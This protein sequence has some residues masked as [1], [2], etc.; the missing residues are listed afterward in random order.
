MKRFFKY[1]QPLISLCIGVFLFWLTFE[2]TPWQEVINR[3]HELDYLWV[4]LSVM[5]GY[6]AYVFRGIRWNLLIKPLGYTVSSITLI[7]AI[8]FSFFCNSAIPRSGEVMRCTSIHKISGI[9]FSTLF[10]HVLLERIIDFIILLTC[11]SVAIAFNYHEFKDFTINF[12]GEFTE[13][14]ESIQLPWLSIAASII[15]IVS[16][17]IYILRKRIFS[18][19]NMLKINAF[20]SGIKTGLLSIKNIQNKPL[21]LIYT[22]GIWL[23]YLLMTSVC[24]RAFVG[25]NVAD[26]TLNEGVFM[27]SAGGIGMVIPSPGGWGSYHLSAKNAMQSL[28]AEETYAELYALVVH[29]S[30]TIMI[31]SAGIIAM[32]I[33]YNQIQKR[34]NG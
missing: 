19:K 21:F 8:A 13:K 23:C 9:P 28:H 7:Q 2:N 20:F 11:I 12:S 16:V 31:I 22:L 30:E 32:I 10:G 34:Y 18:A 26:F 27:L 24:F 14:I 5:F 17:L 3:L 4:L 25:T 33:L 6:L 29:A 1:L 15:L